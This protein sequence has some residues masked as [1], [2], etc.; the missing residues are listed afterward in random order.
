VPQAAYA[1][2]TKH[3]RDLLQREVSRASGRER[4]WFP[5]LAAIVVV[6]ALLGSLRPVFGDDP[7]F[8]L[9]DARWIV[10]HHEIP[11]V[12]HFSYT[13]QGQPWIYPIGGSLLFYG[14]WLI[15][16]YAL[17]SWSAALTT[18]GTTA[19][20]L[21]RG[22]VTSAL[23]AA[24]AVPLVAARTNVRADM[25]TTLLSAA[26][27]ALLWRFHRT[28]RTRLWLLPALMIA[29]VN[30]HLGFVVGLGLICGYVLVELLEFFWP[31][32]RRA[33]AARLRRA[34]PWLLATAA[35]TVLNPFG[36]EIYSAVFRQLTAPQLEVMWEWLSVPLNWNTLALIVAP[37]SEEGA[38]VLLL[39]IAAAAAAVAAWRQEF[40][41]A[42]LLLAAA[43]AAVQHIRSEALL[44]TVT[45]IVGSNVLEA[46]AIPVGRRARPVA[47]ALLATLL[48]VLLV[49]MV[50]RKLPLRGSW[51]T[52]E[53]PEGGIAFIER[54]HIPPQILAT[55]FGAYFTWRLWPKYPVFWDT[56]TMPFGPQILAQLRWLAALP[57]SAPEWRA[58][59]EHYDINAVLAVAGPNGFRLQEF[60]ASD[61]WIPVYLDEVSAVFVRRRPENEGFERLR[62]DCHHP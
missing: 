54:E 49:D 5:A 7:F 41:A 58:A 56:R 4:V 28:G 27:L 42:V 25:F 30:A 11:R 50:P 40:G 46:I 57:P 1:T 35:A 44:A 13:A 43:V 31:E 22:S 15:G 9:N 59:V 52:R 20:M 60:C 17:L 8:M 61:D 45:V 26:Y 48:I 36:I 53:Y 23:L 33:A 10:E 3:P 38:L 21:R 51:V 19:L 24:L 37:L 55:R 29:W 18:A 62:I 47:A 12:D 39:I 14:L 6:Y 16:G 2:N 34:A 32:R